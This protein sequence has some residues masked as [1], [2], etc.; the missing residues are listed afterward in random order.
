[1]FKNADI[2]TDLCPTRSAIQ[3]SSVQARRYT[4]G[5]IPLEHAGALMFAGYASG[6]QLMPLLTSKISLVIHKVIGGQK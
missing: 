2:G 1:M 5:H 6:G 3:S 4:A